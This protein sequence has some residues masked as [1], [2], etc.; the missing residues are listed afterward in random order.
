MRVQ[1]FDHE[2][3]RGLMERVGRYAD[4]KYF[5]HWVIKIIL[6]WIWI[7]FMQFRVLGLHLPVFGFEFES[8]WVEYDESGKMD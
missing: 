7:V 1:G 6:I 8:I 3:L 2:I 5:Y 4:Y